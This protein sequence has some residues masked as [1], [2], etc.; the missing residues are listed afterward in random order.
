MKE[1]KSSYESFLKSKYFSTKH[2]NYFSIYDSLFLSYVG[3]P[4]TFVEVGILGGG[5]SS[6]VERFFWPA[7][8]N[9]RN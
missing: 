3:Q 9:N 1:N 8:T 4:I 6:H 2:T 7:S 5:L